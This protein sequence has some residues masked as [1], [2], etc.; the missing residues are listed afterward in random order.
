MPRK[1]I[2]VSIRILAGV[3]WIQIADGAQLPLELSTELR[4]T[5]QLYHSSDLGHVE[6][7]EGG[8]EQGDG[9]IQQRRVRLNNDM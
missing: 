1:A 4:E 7:R 5:S 9:V 2:S 3:R 6:V 8:G